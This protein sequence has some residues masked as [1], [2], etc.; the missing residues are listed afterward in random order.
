MFTLTFSFDRA[1]QGSLDRIANA[2][3]RIA[4]NGDK[5]MSALSD[6]VTALQAAS[7]AL[8]SAT[9]AL[10]AA[11]AQDDPKGIADAVV[12]LKALADGLNTAA[13]TAQ[14]AVPKTP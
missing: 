2:L 8:I 4:N 5:I 13:A 1:A 11:L 14:S 7:Q 10:E 6:V 12:Q 3:E 9:Q